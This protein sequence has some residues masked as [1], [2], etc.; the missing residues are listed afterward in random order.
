[1]FSALR[2][3]GF[4]CLLVL[5]SASIALAQTTYATIT[6]TVRD[7]SGAAVSDAKITATNVETGVVSTTASNKEGVYTVA[8]LREGSY[9][10]SVQATGFRE[11][12]AADVVLVARDVRRLDVSLVIGALEERVDVA[13]GATLIE[14]ETA[15][16]SDTRTADQLK[17]LPLNDRGIWSF[18]QVTPMLSPRGGSYS[19]AGSRTNQSQFAIDGTTMCDGVTDNAIGPLANYVESFKEVKLDL[20]NNSAEFGSLGQVTILSKS[21]TNGFNGSAFDYYQS[22][23]FRARDPFATVRRAGVQHNI[24]LS[25]GGPVAIPQLYNGRG[26]TFWFASGETFTG[27][28]ASSALNPTVP[29]EAW[30]RGDFSA[31]NLRSATRSLARSTRTDGSLTPPSTPSPG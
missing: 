30:R 1:M 31:L 18:L 6:G 19:F 26:R 11:A 10:V 28:S 4:V 3:A 25:L 14:A 16:V 8:Q 12:L 17:T 2:F 7:P 29:I 13:G 24:G 21:G 20:A 5:T 27:S 22:P 15:R 9:L 23:I